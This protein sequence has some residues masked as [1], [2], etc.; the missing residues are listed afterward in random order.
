M[1]SGTST[2][3]VSVKANLSNYGS[4]AG[5]Q[6]PLYTTNQATNSRLPGNIVTLVNKGTGSAIEKYTPH[7]AFRLTGN[8]VPTAV[9]PGRVASAGVTLQANRAA[10][11]IHTLSLP[12]AHRS[13]LSYMVLA[14]PNTR[15]SGAACYTCTSEV[16]SSTSFCVSCRKEDSTFMDGNFYLYTF[17]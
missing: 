9:N 12:T 8:A 13:G 6:Y 2:K 11:A 1:T 7:I 10:N 4:G 14:M 17:Q 15:G 16:N 3:V 5:M